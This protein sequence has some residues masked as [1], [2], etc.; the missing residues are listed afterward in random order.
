M[1]RGSG[2]LADPM[3]EPPLPDGSLRR[4]AEDLAP[5]FS[6]ASTRDL[7]LELRARLRAADFK[8]DATDLADQ[9]GVLGIEIECCTESPWNRFSRTRVCS[10]AGLLAPAVDAGALS[11]EG[12]TV[13]ELGCGSIHPLGPSLVHVLGGARLAVGVD[14]D[15]IQ[16]P[17]ASARALLRLALACLAAPELVIPWTRRT[18]E[19]VVVALAGFDLAK[20]WHGDQSGLDSR[21]VRLHHGTAERLPFADGEVDACTSVSFLEHVENVDDVLAEMARVLRPGGIAVHTIDGV[22][23][24]SYGNPAVGPLDFLREPA[25]RRL[26]GGCNR[27]RP[28]EFVGH[29]E[30]AGFTSVEFEP[31]A[32]LTIDDAVRTSFAEPWRSM[33]PETLAVVQGAIRARRCG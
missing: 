1:R 30:R 17:A 6:N 28:A 12:A 19:D 9:L 11:L 13:V 3:I 5:R 20:L 29:F 14:L 10:I 15:R 18:R 25:S 27:L 21:R 8:L 7:V 22:D 24:S 2:I 33:P 4:L 16:D 26:V 23:H 32:T 31:H